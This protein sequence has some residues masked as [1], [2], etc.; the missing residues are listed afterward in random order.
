MVP[1]W[2]Y[3][4]V[5]FHADPFSGS[6]STCVQ[7]NEESFLI[8]RGP[9]VFQKCRRNLKSLAARSWHEA[10]FLLGTCKY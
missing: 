1:L 6:Q 9:Q 10:G 4:S 7:T 5:Q 3:T 8:V 2:K